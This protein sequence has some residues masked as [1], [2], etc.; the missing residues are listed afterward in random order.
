MMEQNDLV[1]LSNLG[2][3]IKRHSARFGN[4]ILTVQNRDLLL[5]IEK[6][7]IVNSV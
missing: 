7:S 3:Q 5:H 1:F 4:M 6:V 2:S